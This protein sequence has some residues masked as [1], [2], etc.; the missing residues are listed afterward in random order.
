VADADLARW[1]AET[2]GV[3]S[4]RHLNNAG[5]ALM[6]QPVIDAMLEHIALE[7][8]IGGYEAEAERADAISAAYATVGALVGAAA[9]NIAFVENA[10]VAVAQALSAFDFRAG[11][12]IVT[13]NRDYTSKQLMYLALAERVGVSVRRA[14][15]LPAGGVD[16]ESVR[17]LLRDGRV[18][19]VALTWI[20]TNGGIVQRAEEVGAICGEAGVPYLVDAC[21]AVGQMPV[22]VAE[23]QCDFLAATARKFLRGPRGIGFLY[24]SDS[25][26]ADG[27]YPLALDLRGGSLVA[28][29][30]FTLADSARRFE[31]WEFSYALVLGQAAAVRY[32]LDVGLAVAQERSWALASRVRAGLGAI[33]AAR[34]IEPGERLSAIVTS[35]FEGWDA[36]SLV[37]ALRR[38]GI[39]TSAAVSGPGPLDDESPDASMVRISPHYYNTED[40]VDEA[41]A[42]IA[43]LVR[44]PRRLGRLTG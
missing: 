42:A 26:L 29:D 17:R 2:P 16:P 23:L 39:N 30:R 9:R 18:R 8:R 15:D 7:T 14:D 41:L 35:A 13:T 24:V 33:P 11:D 19:L 27:R 44:Q 6:P 21:Q 38:L 5:A 25:V 31:N 43:D 28:P 32:A 36:L 34:P 4:R 22:S 3:A 12:A 37:V 20:P 10:T 1:R 40:E